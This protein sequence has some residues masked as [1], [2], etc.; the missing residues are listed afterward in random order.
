MRS[1]SQNS[2]EDLWGIHSG[3]V[4]RRTAWV[5]GGGLP[6]DLVEVEAECLE[7]N[8]RPASTAESCVLGLNCLAW[9]GVRLAPPCAHPPRRLDCSDPRLFGRTSVRVRPGIH[10]MAVDLVG[11]QVK[12]QIKGRSPVLREPRLFHVALQDPG[13]HE[14]RAHTRQQQQGPVPVWPAH[15]DQRPPVGGLERPPLAIEPD[16][17]RD[18]ARE[19]EGPH[20]L[21]RLSHLG[22]FHDVEDVQAPVVA[23][24][25]DHA[26]TR[27]F[28]SPAHLDAPRVADN[29]ATTVLCELIGLAAT[30]LERRFHGPTTVPPHAADSYVQVRAS[31]WR[32]VG[33]NIERRL[34][35]LVVD[36]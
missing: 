1:R 19:R 20:P 29:S 32:W 30:M 6:A 26:A 12:V 16:L 18:P 22:L 34:A 14:A 27:P 31:K 2:R 25:D 24:V 4:A 36:L 35:A 9:G 33:R 21:K 8:V 13:D 7:D 28:F 23:G 11:V 15:A 3:L 10:V 17:V 5:R